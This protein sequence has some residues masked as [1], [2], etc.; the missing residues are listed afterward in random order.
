[1][2]E[3]YFAQFGPSPLGG[4]KQQQPEPEQQNYFSQFG[5]SPLNSQSQ[6]Q[7]PTLQDFEKSIT[8][9]PLDKIADTLAPIAVG[10][11]SEAVAPFLKA[12]TSVA[13]KIGTNVAQGALAG[14]EESLGSGDNQSGDLESSALLGAAGG[15]VVGTLAHG[16]SSIYNRIKDID[17]QATQQ[18][19]DLAKKHGI[20]LGIGDLGNVDDQTR[21]GQEVRKFGAEI[22]L[23]GTAGH[24]V[25]QEKGRQNIIN[26]VKARFG[27]YSPSALMD[28]ALGKIQDIKGEANQDYRDILDRMNQTNFPQL[29]QPKGTFK[30]IDDEIQRLT[31]NPNGT[32][33][34][35]I[36]EKTVNSLL[37]TRADLQADPSF[38][39]LRDIRQ[40]FRETVRGDRVAWPN[41]GQRAANN[42]YSAMTGDLQNS[43]KNVLGDT[44]ADKWHNANSALAQEINLEKQTKLKKLLNGGDVNPESIESLLYSMN[45]SDGKNLYNHLDETGRRMAI[46]GIISKALKNATYDDGSP[47]PNKFINQFDKLYKNTNARIFFKGE[48][49]KFVEGMATILN[50]TRFAGN[51]A[52]APDTGSRAAT[53]GAVGLIYAALTHPGLLAAP[54]VYSSVAH[55]YESPA[56]RNLFIK[57]GGMKNKTPQAV[58]NVAAK[59]KSYLDSAQPVGVGAR[60]AGEQAGGNQ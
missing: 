15:G 28:S 56:L 18:I 32:P 54:F 33:K 58:Q 44:A 60:A 11:E 22:P 29:T 5:P 45:E 3:N 42:I 4:G 49:K 10:P 12:F 50:H 9:G 35:S 19:V 2:A 17:P 41:S 27:E 36:D 30:A 7:Q 57:L 39:N 23:I 21:V 31:T 20:D 25:K 24:F 51:I 37:N 46:A 8:D 16:L 52:S 59:I 38:Q 55:F 43:V 13:S 48:D 6:S 53:I 34:Q 26:A 1:M 40:N 14:V 47:I